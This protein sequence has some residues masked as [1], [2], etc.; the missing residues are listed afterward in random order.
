MKADNMKM[1]EEMENA[2]QMKMDYLKSSKL[3]EER[4]LH[5]LEIFDEHARRDLEMFR[6]H[7]QAGRRPLECRVK[8]YEKK[9][10]LVDDQERLWNSRH[11]PTVGTVKKR[12]TTTMSSATTTRDIK[13]SAEENRDEL[14]LNLPALAMRRGVLKNV[15]Q[16]DYF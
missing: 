4:A 9:A 3:I 8:K 6:L 2:R 7:R 15:H 16:A 13:T 14:V 12:P 1:Q 5:E 11:R 10:E